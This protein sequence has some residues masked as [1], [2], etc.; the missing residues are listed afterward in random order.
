MNGDKTQGRAKRDG[1][2]LMAS[3]VNVA[4]EIDGDLLMGLL[5]T[6][7][8]WRGVGLLRFLSPHVQIDKNLL[9]AS[10]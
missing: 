2:K 6:G 4:I 10:S 7:L 3:R 8:R 9:A 5:R 1:V